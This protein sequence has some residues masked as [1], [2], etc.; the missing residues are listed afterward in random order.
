[1]ENQDSDIGQKSNG[2][3]VGVV[4][5]VIILIISGIYLLKMRIDET[6]KL[7]SMAAQQQQ[8]EAANNAANS[9]SASDEMTSIESDLNTNS[10]VD[11]IDQGLQ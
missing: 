3:L 11:G 4:I 9:L 2:A 8:Q 1:M 7:E 6:K 10:S 5:I